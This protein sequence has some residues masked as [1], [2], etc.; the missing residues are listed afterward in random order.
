M[1][2][3]GILS[4]CMSFS[5]M[6]RSGSYGRQPLFHEYPSGDRSETRSGKKTVIPFCLTIISNYQ[7]INFPTMRPITIDNAPRGNSFNTITRI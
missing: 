3:P 7:F 4:I 6:Q 2:H 1:H 5:H